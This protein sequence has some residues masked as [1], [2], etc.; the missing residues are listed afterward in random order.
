[1]KKLVNIS[2]LLLLFGLNSVIAQDN[3]ERKEKI[4]IDGQ[5]VTV[6]ITETNDTLLI[7]DLDDVAVST[8]RD[9]ADKDEY[10]KFL[11]YRRYAAKVYP[12]AVDA[13]R[14]F[15][16]SEEA[17]YT[18]KRSKRKK[19]FKR[20]QKELKKEFKEPLKKLTRTQGKIL[21]KMIEKEL[22][23]PLYTLMKNLRGGATATY[24]NSMGKLYGYS[25]KT[26]YIVGE[27][28]IMDIV[29]K[30]FDVSHASKE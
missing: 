3:K 8:P 24:Y 15:R 13:I 1:M 23:T 21:V 4:T 11:K 30:D 5:L 7:A 12:Y 17:Y 20:L 26:G 28:K 25:L 19:H 18:M 22:D 27:D 10:R 9:F 14:I 2:F 29:L 16:E 6:L